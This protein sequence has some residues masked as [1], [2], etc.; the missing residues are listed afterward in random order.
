MKDT[1][2][3]INKNQSDTMLAT[4]LEYVLNKP[5]INL[6]SCT[7]INKKLCRFQNKNVCAIAFHGK[8]NHRH[9]WCTWAAPVRSEWL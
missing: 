3:I 2:I 6:F 9:V 7:K 4:D 1:Y 5:S 8:S